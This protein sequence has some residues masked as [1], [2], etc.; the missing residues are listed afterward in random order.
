MLAWVTATSLIGFGFSIQLFFRLA[1]GSGRL[2]GNTRRRCETADGC[3]SL[4][5]GSSWPRRRRVS[6]QV[7]PCPP[8]K[9]AA[10][11]DPKQPPASLSLDVCRTDHLAPFLGVF[12]NEASRVDWREY[13]DCEP[14]HHG[15]ISRLLNVTY[16]ESSLGCLRKTVGNMMSPRRDRERRRRANGGR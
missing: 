9:L 5:Q 4:T 10:V 12:G 6:E 14:A 11:D 8:R 3:E 13:K 16:R 1:R 15:A 2:P 7:F